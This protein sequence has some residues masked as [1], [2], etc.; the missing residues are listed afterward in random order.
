MNASLALLVVAIAMTL[1]IANGSPVVVE[2]G[3]PESDIM[4]GS[5]DAGEDSRDGTLDVQFAAYSFDGIVE[6]GSNHKPS[7][8][9]PMAVIEGVADPF[10]HGGYIDTGDAPWA[11]VPDIV[12]ENIVPA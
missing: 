8:S 4:D 2:A 12:A 11:G 1:C 6:T 3:S 5:V 9:L 7:H 10:A